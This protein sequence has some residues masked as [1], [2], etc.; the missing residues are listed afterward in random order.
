MKL[1]FEIEPEEVLEYQNLFVENLSPSIGMTSGDI[2]RFYETNYKIFGSYLNEV[3]KLYD[4]NKNI[5]TGAF[6]E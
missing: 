1:T 2:M 4:L 3:F 5:F 6:N